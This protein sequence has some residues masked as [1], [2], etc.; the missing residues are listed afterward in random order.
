MTTG[1]QQLLLLLFDPGLDAFTLASK[2]L[3]LHLGGSFSLGLVERL[4]SSLQDF[5][6]LLLRASDCVLNLSP[7]ALV[8]ALVVAQ[9][10]ALLL[11]ILEL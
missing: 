5:P 8:Q 4:L 3:K 7:N 1:R 6:P 10:P 11:Q 9:T 2:S